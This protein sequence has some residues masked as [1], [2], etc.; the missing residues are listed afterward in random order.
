MKPKPPPVDPLTRGARHGE[1]V[2]LS[3]VVGWESE[4]RPLEFRVEDGKLVATPP[5][6]SESPR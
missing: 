5:A 2:E 1:Q 3:T 4:L 6:T